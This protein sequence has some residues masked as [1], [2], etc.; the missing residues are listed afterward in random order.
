MDY[1][2][3]EISIQDV[4]PLSASIFEEGWMYVTS[5]RDKSAPLYFAP[6]FTKE[7][8]I[9]GIRMMSRVLHTEIVVLANNPPAYNAPT[10]SEHNSQ[11]ECGLEMLKKRAHKE[12]WEHG[13]SRLLYLDK[14]MEIARTPISKSAF[15]ATSPTKNI[16]NQIPK[17]FHLRFDELIRSGLGFGSP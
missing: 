1:Y 2:D 14:P 7:N 15:N 6:Y 13:E 10:K 4:N 16:P 5:T 12:G 3:A 8:P 17:G 9:S 11:W